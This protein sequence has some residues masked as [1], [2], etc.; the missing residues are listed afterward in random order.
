MA[1]IRASPHRKA[2][3]QAYDST[4]EALRALITLAGP[5]LPEACVFMGWSIAED[6]AVL[7]GTTEGFRALKLDPCTFS[8]DGCVIASPDGAVG[9]IFDFDMPSEISSGYV[10]LFGRSGAWEKV[11]PGTGE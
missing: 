10:H 4:P 6:P 7:M 8:A 1:E 3:E 11:I 9:A 5:V 2:Y